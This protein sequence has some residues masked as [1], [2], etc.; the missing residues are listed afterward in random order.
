[1]TRN[2]SRYLYLDG[3][4]APEPTDRFAYT[5]TPRERDFFVAEVRAFYRRRRLIRAFTI[6]Y[7]VVCLLAALVLVGKLLVAELILQGW[8]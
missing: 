3:R 5:L 8:V 6:A 7:F 2:N 4:P 1:M